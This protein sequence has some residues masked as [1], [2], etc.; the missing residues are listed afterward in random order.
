[1][2]HRAIGW[3]AGRRNW[4]VFEDVS[5]R[6]CADGGVAPEKD[7][8]QETQKLKERLDQAKSVKWR[9]CSGAAD[10]A[11]VGAAVRRDPGH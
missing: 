3:L 7:K 1:M 10:G 8:V 5:G 6:E 11:R 2:R 9:S 4:P